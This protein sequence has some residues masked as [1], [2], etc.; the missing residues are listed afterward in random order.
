MCNESISQHSNAQSKLS[1]STFSCCSLQAPFLFASIFMRVANKKKMIKDDEI[2]V[3]KQ[4]IEKHLKES[5]IY[6][7]SNKK[8]NVDLIISY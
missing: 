4:P 2:C 8:G 3:Y 5:K 6:E 7:L 1:L